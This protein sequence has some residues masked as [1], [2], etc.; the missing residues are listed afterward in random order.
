MRI[1]KKMRK[2]KAAYWKRSSVDKFGK[3]SYE[4][5][6]LI[7][8]R[9]E[10]VRQEYRDSK[11]QICYSQSVVYVDRE[12]SV[13][14][15]LAKTST[16]PETANPKAEGGFEIHSMEQIPTLKATKTLFVAYL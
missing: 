1:I 13:G 7:D 8:C 10:D 11:G 3:Y 5:P 6:I 12:M 14:D 15:C 16:L 9:W 2:Q 4:D